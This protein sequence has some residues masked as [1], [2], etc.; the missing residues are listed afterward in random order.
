MGNL[1]DTQ[2]RVV[3]S[4]WLASSGLNQDTYATKHGISAR[5]LR[6]WIARY[7]CRQPAAD[8]VRE[9][10]TQLVELMEKLQAALTALDVPGGMP[11]GDEDEA[12]GEEPERPASIAAAPAGAACPVAPQPVPLPRPRPAPA[13]AAPVAAPKLNS[14]GFF[15]IGF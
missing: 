14:R 6:S 9:V 1:T 3:V 13:P 2:R 7:P 15:D 10:A 11:D 4:G 8:Q 12:T 5:T